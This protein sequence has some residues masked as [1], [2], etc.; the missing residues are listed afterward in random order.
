[1]SSCTAPSITKPSVRNS[2]D[3]LFACSAPR[4]F[5]VEEF[6][7]DFPILREEI[8][9]HVLSYLD[10][11]ASAQK[12]RMVTDAM[13]RFMDHDYANIHR[14]VHELS[15]RATA[16]YEAVRGTIRRFIN[17]EYDDEIVFTKNAT[18]AVNLVAQSWGRKF[19]QAGDEII[20]T[21][22][23]HHANIV[24]WQMLR[25]QLGIVLRIIPVT[26]DGEVEVEDVQK[27]FSARTKLVALAHISN[28]LGTILPVRK[29]AEIAHQS[30]ALVLVDGCQS[31]AHMPVDV[32]DLGADFFVFI[33]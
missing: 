8:H 19:L 23:E 25:E 2:G 32:R 1:M 18:E 13:Q 24:P 15:V 26:A 3:E 30:G 31:V 9:G 20:I 5:L 16:K 6:R 12:P 14:G 28:V 11:G 17:A 29:I 33:P 27:A 22:L 10:T 7:K 21:A 4:E